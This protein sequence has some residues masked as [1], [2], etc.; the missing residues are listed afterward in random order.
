MTMDDEYDDLPFHPVEIKQEEQGFTLERTGGCW[1]ASAPDL[2]PCASLVERE[3]LLMLAD[4]AE[5]AGQ[6]VLVARLRKAA[7]G[8]RLP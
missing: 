7:E 6:D 8:R 3:A 2:P 5:G 1:I 4:E